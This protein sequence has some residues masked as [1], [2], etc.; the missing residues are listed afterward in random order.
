[1]AGMANLGSLF[2]YVHRLLIGRGK[3]SGIAA[4]G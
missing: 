1:M 2:D 3:G 4:F